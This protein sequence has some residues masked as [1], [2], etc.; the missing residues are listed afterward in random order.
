MRFGLNPNTMEIGKSDDIQNRT[1]SLAT[2]KWGAN[3]TYPD[4]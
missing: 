2:N 3:K 1:K 4:F